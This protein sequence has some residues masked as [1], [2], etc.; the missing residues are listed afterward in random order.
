MD[1]AQIV[2]S[3]FELTPIQQNQFSQLKPL[4]EDWNS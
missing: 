2:S 1:N 4:Y 3:Q